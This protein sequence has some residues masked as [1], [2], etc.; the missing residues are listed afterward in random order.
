VTGGDIFRTNYAGRFFIC[1]PPNKTL[2]L[3]VD[4]RKYLPY[5]R[6]FAVPA[7]ANRS[8]YRIDLLLS[9]GIA[10]R[11]PAP[12]ERVQEPPP[13]TTDTTRVLFAFEAAELARPLQKSLRQFI[14]ARGVDNITGVTV[15]GYTDEIG[16]PSY[17]QRLSER[18]AASV[19]RLL[20][21]MG[22]S[23]EII[24]WRGRGELSGRRER[25][26]NRRVEITL[27]LR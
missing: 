21:D 8:P 19:V 14:E 16:S 12:Q 26:Q 6:D 7:W 27:R 4:H 22:I 5:R 20:T 24:E 13:V 11:G 25:D 17:N 23:E 18:R 2:P 15:S 1:A 10:S 9:E 3:S